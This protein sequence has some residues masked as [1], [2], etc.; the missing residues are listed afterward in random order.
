MKTHA[1]TDIGLVRQENQDACT[2]LSFPEYDGALAVVCD[3]MGGAAG[4]SIASRLAIEHFTALMTELLQNHTGDFDDI[5][6][7]KMFGDA[8]YRANREVFDRAVITPELKGMGTTLTAALLMRRTLYLA[9]IGDSRAYLL[10]S[11]GLARLTHDDSYVQS[12]IDEGRMTEEEAEHSLH[13]NLLTRALGTKPYTDFS[14]GSFLLEAGDRLLL[15]SDGLTVCCRDREIAPLLTTV[16]DTK[17]AAEAMIA[18]ARSAGGPD[19][20]TA[21]IIDI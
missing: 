12:M 2:V 14:F 18:A 8:V 5:S 19:N 9:N 13:R 15:C 7:Q 6:V 11:A 1:V 16:K 17:E 3:G 4:G 20:I 10:R 21:V